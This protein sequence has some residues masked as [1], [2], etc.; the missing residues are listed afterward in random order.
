MRRPRAWIEPYAGTLSVTL[1]LVTGR[2]RPPIGYLGSKRRMA[3]AILDAL[4]LCLGIG[5]EQLIAADVGPWRLVWAQ[6]AS[7]AG[8]A[9][10]AR[11]LL[12]WEGQDIRETWAALAAE[13][14]APGWLDDAP[15]SPRD[16]ALYLI[17]Q[18]RAAGCVPVYARPAG[19]RSHH[20]AWR[21]SEYE[22][23]PPQMHTGGWVGEFGGGTAGRW[24]EEPRQRGRDRPDAAP[25]GTPPG[26]LWVGHFHGGGQQEAVICGKGHARGRIGGLKRPATIARRLLDLHRHP[27]PPLTLYPRAETIPIPADASGWFVYLDPPYVGCTGYAERP[28]PGRVAELADRWRHAGAVVAISEAVGLASELGW[29]WELELG[30][31]EVLTLSRPSRARQLSLLEAG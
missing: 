23:A 1:C 9:A 10:V 21:D 31:R 6:I 24:E 16:I 28:P 18:G 26:P 15:L 2:A 5:A 14:V 22:V 27:W 17:L 25:E 20:G 30:P 12:Q 29:G 19:W 13:P 11:E 8:A 4:G 3:A 7:P